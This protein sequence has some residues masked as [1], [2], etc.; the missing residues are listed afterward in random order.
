MKKISFIIVSL[1]LMS[2]TSTSSIN[3]E[4][5]NS[6]EEDTY[7]IMEYADHLGFSIGTVTC[8][9]NAFYAACLGY[10]VNYDDCFE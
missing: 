9:G 8:M 6:C 5:Y 1:L 4:A 7:D 2:M 3:N 10:Y